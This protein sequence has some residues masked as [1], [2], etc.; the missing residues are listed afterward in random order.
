MHETRELAK[1][2]CETKYD[3]LPPGLVDQLRIVVLDGICAGFVGSTQPAARKVVDLVCDLGGS[4]QATV[5]NERFKTDVARAALANGTLIGAFECEPLTGAHASGTV[6]PAALAMAEREHLDGRAF[7]TAIAVGYEISGRIQRTAV[8]LES[9]RGFHNP[10]T[11]GPFGAAAA[12][13]KLLGF[14]EKT[15]VNALGVAGSTSAGLIEFAWEGADTKRIHLGRASQLGLES[16]LLARSG[17]TGPSTVIEGKYGYFNAF[18][19]PTD[20]TKVLRDLGTK[21]AIQ[22]GAHKS[23]ATHNSHQSTVHAIQEFKKKHPFDPRSVGAVSVRGS[24][25]LT[26]GRHSVPDPNT[27]MGG[28]Y[29]LPFTTAVALARDMSDPLIYNDETLA[30]PLIREIAMRVE[31]IT[32]ETVDAVAGDQSVITLEID[33][34]RHVITTTPHPGSRENPF[35]WD[36]VSAKFRRYT[37]RIIS[38]EQATAVIDVVGRI[39]DVSDM[40][41]VA[42]AT[43]GR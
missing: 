3:Q 23:Y 32:D 38:P 10:G 7:L 1:F 20:V 24:E 16:A 39:T 29:S 26:E 5:I 14:D 37:A 21:W 42:S 8:G 43:S 41:E 33:G 35:T 9:E 40:A 11:Q 13:G 18:S 19:M 4:G 36:Q 25:R 27:V 2:A 22:P 12:I 6:L 31:L 34:E 15:M 30:D 17:F 28:Q